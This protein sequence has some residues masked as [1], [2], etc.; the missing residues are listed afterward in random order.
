[1]DYDID[2]NWFD[3][4]TLKAIDA[5]FDVDSGIDITTSE[6]SFGAGRDG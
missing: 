2:I 4:E 1:L 3:D 5:L 6:T